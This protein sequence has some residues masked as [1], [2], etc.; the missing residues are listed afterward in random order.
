MQ[1]VISWTEAYP[2]IHHLELEVFTDNFRAISLYLKLGF[3]VEGTKR[4]ACRKHGEFKD[5]YMMALLVE[6]EEPAT[7]E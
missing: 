6:D 3:V 2:A 7:I 4:K 5:S 1:T